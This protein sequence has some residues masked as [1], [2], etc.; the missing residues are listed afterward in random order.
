MRGASSIL[1]QDALAFPAV[2]ACQ[3]ALFLISQRS[4]P[5]RCLGTFSFL[6]LKVEKDF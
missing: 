6:F 1:D 3:A 4:D 2:P 5:S